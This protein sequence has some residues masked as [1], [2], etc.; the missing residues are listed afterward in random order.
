MELPNPVGSSLKTMWGAGGV[1]VLFCRVVYYNEYY[2]TEYTVAL[3]RPTQ[4][5]YLL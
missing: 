5:C 1:F 2:I 4:P 3:R